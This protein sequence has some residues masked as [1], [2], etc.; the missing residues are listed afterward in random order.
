MK[1]CDGKGRLCWSVAQDKFSVVEAF[2][3]VAKLETMP[4]LLARTS[5]RTRL[6]ICYFIMLPTDLHIVSHVPVFPLTKLCAPISF[7]FLK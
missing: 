7:P 5:M 4:L 2:L 6:K 3:N 1:R